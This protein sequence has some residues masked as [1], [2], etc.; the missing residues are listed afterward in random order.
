M[1]SYKNRR[2]RNI[3]ERP[4]TLI[5]GFIVYKLQGRITTDHFVRFHFEQRM[6]IFEIYTVNGEFQ[7]PFYEFKHGDKIAVTKIIVDWK[8]APNK[9]FGIITTDLVCG[10]SENRKQQV[11]TFVKPSKTTIT[12]VEYSH[13]T[14]YGVNGP[15][16]QDAKFAIESMF[17]DKIP[18][19]KNLYM[20]LLIK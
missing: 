11:C 10:F 4:R 7:L 8:T 15:F 1:L 2:F 20:Q 6:K 12:E 14:F 18:E 17:G 9:V 5:S 3:L 19:I 16:L 13:P